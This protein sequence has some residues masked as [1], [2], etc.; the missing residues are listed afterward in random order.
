MTREDMSGI[1]QQQRQRKKKK[2]KN[3]RNE[4]TFAVYIFLN[5][6]I[7]SIENLWRK[8]KAL[9]IIL[10]STFLCIFH[11]SLNILCIAVEL[12]RLAGSLTD[13]VAKYN[14]WS[15]KARQGYTFLIC[16][17]VIAS[18]VSSKMRKLCAC[19]CVRC[20]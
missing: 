12:T 5:R 11:M 14:P 9:F 7:K 4:N 3:E 19:A 18:L 15:F 6:K 10:L 20:F 16:V 8:F 13:C 2:K 1:E 17:I